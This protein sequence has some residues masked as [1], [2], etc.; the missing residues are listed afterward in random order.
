[1]G[2]DHVQ[3][4]VQP[5]DKNFDF[6]INADLVQPAKRAQAVDFSE[7]YYDVSPALVALKGTP[8]TGATRS[9]T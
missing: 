2:V 8:I 1:M 6:D 4:I 5:G 9:R 7:S 3:R